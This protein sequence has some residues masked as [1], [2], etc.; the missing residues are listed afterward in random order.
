[1]T[2]VMVLFSPT[3]HNGTSDSLAA[4][5]AIS[6]ASSVIFINVPHCSFILQLYETISQ[7][8]RSGPEANIYY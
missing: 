8:G 5:F 3:S 6:K 4:A 1:M 7:Y 2:S